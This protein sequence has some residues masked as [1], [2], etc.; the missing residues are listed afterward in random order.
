[1]PDNPCPT[2]GHEQPPVVHD[3]CVSCGV[4]LVDVF[5]NPSCRQYSEA[6][7]VK[8]LGGYGMFFD[9]IVGDSVHRRG[10]PIVSFVGNQQTTEERPMSTEVEQLRAVVA[11]VRN[12]HTGTNNHG[13]PWC[14]ECNRPAPCPTLQTVI[15]GS[16]L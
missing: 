16:T 8:L 9:T 3:N 2:C 14:W 12:T 4:E 7:E 15:Q 1:M 5:N 11:S 10:G 6:L 13:K